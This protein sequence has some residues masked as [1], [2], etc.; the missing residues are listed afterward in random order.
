MSAPAVKFTVHPLAELIPPMS[1]REY[2]D[3]KADLEANGQQEP[4]TLYEGKILD[5]RHRARA[6]DELNLRPISRTYEGDEPA[7]YVISL[8]LTRRDL[9]VSQRA[10]VA[11]E[12]L[13]AL[14]EEGRKRQG[15][16]T[17]LTSSSKELEVTSNGTKHPRS[18]EIAAEICGVAHAQIGRAK[19][20]KRDAPDDFERIRRGE[21]SIGAAHSKLTKPTTNP[22]PSIQPINS[23]R[24]LQMANSARL[25]MERA[26]GMAAGIS[27]GYPHLRPDRALAVATPEEVD[28]WLSTFSEATKAIRNLKQ[29]VE[30]IR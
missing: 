29:Q 16:R 11:V 7:A 17:D 28:G 2:A 18:R 6:L 3:L 5:G 19:R 30:A 25:R 22:P 24:A 21:I 8:N 1:S 27:S 20:V 4:I 13:P 9:T 14:E 10:A 12:F 26:V 15:E 23:K